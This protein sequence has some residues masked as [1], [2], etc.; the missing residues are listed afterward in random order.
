MEGFCIDP[1]KEDFHGLAT[2]YYE[3]GHKAQEVNYQNGIAH[4]KATYYFENGRKSKELIYQNGE[5]HGRLTAWFEDGS[6][7]NS[8]VYKNDKFY[9]GIEKTAGRSRDYADQHTVFNIYKEGE[10]IGGYN[11]YED[12]QQIAFKEVRGGDRILIKTTFYDKSGKEIGELTYGG[13][14]KGGPLIEGPP[15]N[16][17]EVEFG[18][19]KGNGYGTGYIKSIRQWINGNL[20]GA[21]TSFDPNG[22]VIAKGV[23]KNSHRFSGRFYNHRERSLDVL[24]DGEYQ[25]TFKYKDDE[26]K[27]ITYHAPYENGKINGL[28]LSVHTD[29]NEKYECI[30]KDWKPYD[31]KFFEFY[32]LSTYKDGERIEFVK[33][34]EGTGKIQLKETTG[35]GS[36]T[37]T[38]FMDGAVPNELIYKDGKIYQGVF[39]HGNTSTTYIEGKRQGPY[40]TFFGYPK[41][42][43]TGN[44]HEDELKG[45]V[46]FNNT[47]TGEVFYCEFKKGVPMD[48]TVISEDKITNY[49]NG[50]KHGVETQS[51]FRER[52]IE[53]ENLALAEFDKIT[54]TYQDGILE[55]NITYFLNE[56]KVGKGIYKNET[57]FD[58]IFYD[59]K[60][61]TVLNKGELIQKTYNVL[62]LMVEDYF[63]DGKLIERISKVEDST[64]DFTN[65]TFLNGQPY[66]GTI[67]TYDEGMTMADFMEY[68]QVGGFG[69]DKTYTKT[70][71]KNGQKQ[72]KETVF[73]P[74]PNG[75]TIETVY[76]K[77]IPVSKTTFG[78]DFLDENK[79]MG[80]YKN[81]LPCDG[82]FFT[83]GKLF[84]ILSSY[85][86][87]ELQCDQF[88][89]TNPEETIL[90][91]TLNYKDGKPFQGQQLERYL[92]DCHQHFYE[93][94]QLIKTRIFPLANNHPE[95]E[96]PHTTE[97]FEIF[98]LASL[99]YKLPGAEIIYTDTGFE[100]QPI[101]GFPDAP[102]F[103]VDYTDATK[104]A[105]TATSSKFHSLV[106]EKGKVVNFEMFE[107]QEADD[108]TSP[109]QS[110]GFDLENRLYQ[111]THK[112]DY[113]TQWIMGD[114]F[115]KK[116]G[117][118]DF[119]YLIYSL[120]STKHF[121]LKESKFPF[122]AMILKKTSILICTFIRN[123]KMENNIE[124]NVASH[125]LSY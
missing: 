17:T 104:S 105:G 14:S 115:S 125:F 68:A 107:P 51:F 92:F 12:S 85:K 53:S 26:R 65:G 37:V 114:P 43:V 113:F 35:N 99:F 29:T 10:K 81:A 30:F 70:H 59:E 22:E 78:L 101:D 25:E 95:L 7:Q 83:K 18:S 93:N 97:N 103:K 110:W 69:Y 88:Y 48:G 66:E 90:Y 73:L 9:D 46:T 72:G 55:G 80:K 62:N 87:G 75:I 76:E 33:Y 120:N 8:C 119:Y 34:E 3:N 82:Q 64:K 112:K 36:T 6:V 42:E 32:E 15:L 89:L 77:D 45:K 79:V 60:Y 98:I 109:Q 2:W 116:P 123:L 44:Y 71:Y 54:Q 86:D 94:G 49:K 50:K 102:Y 5:R 84:S 20:E 124:K 47:G 1:D 24:K 111:T 40:S 16:G 96:S 57:P 58:G 21:V 91:A 41:I 121:Y 4:G 23:Y 118:K 11:L 67:L 100:T 108:Y 122:A 27:Q 56:E 52:G 13:N 31:G 38:N 28:V 63:Q 39:E 74:T 61:K 117:Y 19:T 106:F